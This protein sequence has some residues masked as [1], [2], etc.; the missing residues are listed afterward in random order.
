MGLVTSTG[1][2]GA[3]LWAGLGGAGI[4]VVLLARGVSASKVNWSERVGEGRGDGLSSSVVVS[5]SSPAGSGGKF[6]GGGA[7]RL[8]VGGA[9]RLGQSLKRAV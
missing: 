4:I 2:E 1:G 7:E 3:A 8:R 6:S 5:I 9:G